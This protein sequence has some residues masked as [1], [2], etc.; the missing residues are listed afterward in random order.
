VD[1]KQL[2]DLLTESDDKQQFVD[3]RSSNVMHEHSLEDY[4]TYWL[5]WFPHYFDR[6]GE[7]QPDIFGHFGS[8]LAVSCA[9]KVPFQRLKKETDPRRDG[10]DSSSPTGKRDRDDGDVANADARKSH[11]SK[12]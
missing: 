9:D 11:K 7:W 3:I 6:Y 1:S 12:P 4:Y 8:L 5:E 10:D 2:K